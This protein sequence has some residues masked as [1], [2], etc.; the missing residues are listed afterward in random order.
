MTSIIISKFCYADIDECAEGTHNCHMM[1]NATCFD[2]DGSF[3]CS[4]TEGF[5]GN[6]TFC[7]GTM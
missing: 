7:D 3:Y 4:C 2:T 5:E 6:A 1:S